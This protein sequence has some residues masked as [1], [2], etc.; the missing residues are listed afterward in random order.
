MYKL[1]PFVPHGVNLYFW[2]SWSGQVSLRCQGYG[3]QAAMSFC[4]VLIRFRNYASDTHTDVS[5]CKIIII[6]LRVLHIF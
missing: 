2:T 4:D 1:T 5:L 3:G 6:I